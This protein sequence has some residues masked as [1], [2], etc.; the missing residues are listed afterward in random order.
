MRS[1]V[2]LAQRYDIS[3]LIIGMTVVAVGTSAPELVVSMGAALEGAPGLAVGNVVGSNIANVLL[4]LGIAALI[5]PIQIGEAT[6]RRDGAMVVSGTLFFIALGLHGDLD[7]M[8]GILLLISFFVFLGMSYW[9]DT[10][11][12]SDANAQTGEVIKEFEGWPKSTLGSFFAV[13]A[14]PLGLFIG[15]ELLI[16]GGVSIART[17]GVSEEVIGL[18]LFAFGT[19][20]PELA[21]T[22]AAARRGHADVGLGNVAGSNLFNILGVAGATAL[23]APLPMSKQIV[24]FDVWVM[25][26]STLI[27]VPVLAMGCRISRL[28]GG[29]MLAAYLVY[30]WI[31][32][33]GVDELI[34]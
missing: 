24:T 7:T 8:A 2:M 26:A 20:V 4:I 18:T 22:I 11:A 13:I 14:G 5:I 6:L 28:T 31:Q 33:H 34:G 30:I 10:H 15:A 1:A 21:A 19:S 9:R 29:G 23:V 16:D 17:W 27:L 32:I 3:P 12:G 25:L